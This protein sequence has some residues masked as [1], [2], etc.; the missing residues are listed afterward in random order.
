M[1]KQL[2]KA[3][4]DDL[5]V[6][7][8]LWADALKLLQIARMQMGGTD[9]VF[10]SAKLVC[11]LALLSIDSPNPRAFANLCADSLMRMPLEVK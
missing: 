7:D 8:P 3:V 5:C 9:P 10:V 11:A 6:T 4:L 2:N 1:S